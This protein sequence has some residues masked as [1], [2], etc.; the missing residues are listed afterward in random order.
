[1]ED[2][3]RELR[4]H[5]LTDI[6]N[7]LKSAH[8][9]EHVFHLII[10]KLQRLYHCQTCAIILIDPKTE[11]LRVENS[12]GL[13]LTFCK[14][15]RTRVTTGMIG[16]LLWTGEPICIPD[17]Q[18]DSENADEVQLEK[19]F[20][21]CI[22]VQISVNQRTLGYLHV[23]SREVKSFS[24]QDVKIVQLFADLAGLALHKYCLREKILHLER[25]DPITGLD[26][27]ATF[28]EKV[29]DNF[30]RASTFK[31]SF[32]LILFDID[33][34]KYVTNT[35]GTEMG[36]ELVKEIGDLLKS[37]IRNVDAACRFGID[38]FVIL[39]P[40][41]ELESALEFAANLRKEIH[42]KEFTDQKFDSSISVGVSVYPVNGATVEEVMLT[43]K[44]ALFEAQRAGRNAVMYYLSGWYSGE[45]ISFK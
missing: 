26:T 32:S 16:K 1:M 6:V 41:T 24:K 9:Y 3:V 10:D 43:G 17:S 33:N 13:S 5:H 23:D 39:L 37:R 2:T 28:M 20:G 31:E 29:N 30:K 42:E 22:A 21:S 36:T 4:L 7:E 11:Y 15:F 19:S 18:D 8:Q 12:S 35:Y 45:P 27:Y 40:K 38:E 25:V 44:H 14:K 34:F